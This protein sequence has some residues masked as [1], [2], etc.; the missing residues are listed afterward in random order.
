MPANPQQVQYLQRVLNTFFN[1]FEY[2]NILS[3]PNATPMTRAFTHAGALAIGYGGLAHIIRRLVQK[4]IEKNWDLSQEKLK[5]YA[6]ARYPVVNMDAKMTPTE[7]EDIE[8]MGIKQLPEVFRK[9]A[10]QKQAIIESELWR[11]MDPAKRWGRG[12]MVGGQDPAHFALAATAAILAGYSGWKIADYIEDKRKNAALDQ[13]TD[14]AERKL[15]EMTSAEMT[16]TR[17]Q[18]TAALSPWEMR[19]LNPR[20]PGFAAQSPE[21]DPSLLREA[22]SPGN[23]GKGME[24]LYWAWVALALALSYKAGKAYVEQKDP[25]RL[26][27]KELQTL[28]RE[29]AKSKEAPI[30]L[31]T[32]PEELPPSNRQLTSV[33]TNVE[34][35]APPVP[36]TP[37]PAPE[38][39]APEAELLPKA[40]PRPR[41]QLPRVSKPEPVAVDKTDPYAGLL[42]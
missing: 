16:R 22:T 18:K 28:A 40:K 39:P 7:Q 10:M 19:K 6:G 35:P 27:I 3:P 9:E 5:S 2:T 1:P 31:D 36:A 14:E 42:Q 26:R 24:A 38:S 37:P 4:S 23:V 25:A 34:S 15:Q 12:L 20:M 41:L 21:R 11:V 29:R 33:K 13:Q 8:E 17:G 32:M 30:L